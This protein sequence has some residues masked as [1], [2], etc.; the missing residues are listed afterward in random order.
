MWVWLHLFLWS[1]AAAPV[2]DA[3]F[4]DILTRYNRDAQM[5][6]PALTPRQR[7]DMLS[8]KVLQHLERRDDGNWWVAG[9]LVCQ[10]TKESLW[11]ATQDLH[12]TS[13]DDAIEANVSMAPH[14]ASWYA[15]L[16]LPRPFSDRHWVIDVWDNVTLAK[17]S[18]NVFW[19]HPWKLREGGAELVRP[20]VERG[21]VEGLDLATFDAAV[22]TPINEGAWVFIDL[23]DGRSLIAY[24]LVTV[25][26]GNIPDRLVA[27]FVRRNME[28][29]LRTLESRAIE[30][31]PQHYRS[32]HT[33]VLGVNDAPVPFY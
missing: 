25:V 9:M 3:V 24:H 30:V 13:Q 14:Q 29:Q 12:F 33:P 7:A 5:P 6:L 17:A 2:N 4:A 20:K 27:E 11:L 1:V 15:L 32:G 23:P 16:D 18:D 21:E 22:Y 31:V 28:N 19:E 8:G 10:C 26:G